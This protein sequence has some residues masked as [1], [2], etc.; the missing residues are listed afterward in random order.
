MLQVSMRARGE[1]LV[2]DQI[3]EALVTAGWTSDQKECQC[4]DNPWVWDYVAI[5]N[6]DFGPWLRLRCVY[7]DQTGYIHLPTLQW[8]IDKPFRNDMDERAYI[9]QMIFKENKA[10]HSTRCSHG[11]IS[12]VG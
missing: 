11:I 2:D 1:S 7:T 5:F 9:R 8:F 6:Q 10:L 12:Q 4:Y 3:M